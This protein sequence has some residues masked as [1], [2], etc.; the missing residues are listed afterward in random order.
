MEVVFVNQNDNTFGGNSPC[1]TSIQGA[2]E[3]A[4]T[5]V[6]IKIAGGTYD[7]SFVLNESKLLTLSGRWNDGF[8]DQT[9]DTTIIKAPRATQ[10]SLTLQN[11]NI[12]P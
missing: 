6:A 1:Y 2:I 8:T 4:D 3:A 9:G 5:G 11:V 10:G 7:E 12:K